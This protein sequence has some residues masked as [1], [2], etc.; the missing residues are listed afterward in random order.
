MRLRLVTAFFA[1]FACGLAFLAIFLWQSGRLRTIAAAPHSP[2]SPITQPATPP[3]R[4]PDTASP[5]LPPKSPEPA[6]IA[7][8]PPAVEAPDAAREKL[9]DRIPDQALTSRKLLMPVQGVRAKELRDN[10]NE[11]RGNH[12]H[13]A[14]D[15]MAPRG[16][17]VLAADEGNVVKLFLS[18]PGGLT[19]YQFDDSRTYCYYYAHLDRYAPALKEGMLLRKGDVLGYVGSSG[20]ASPGAP[21]LHFAIFKLGP[22]QHWWQGT[23]I[24]P[25]RTL[26]SGGE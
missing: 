5:Y 25:Y 23:P 9:P 7:A 2:P 22:E 4:K 13:E 17:P 21:H 14:I 15:I 12:R 11:I 26:T 19:V 3:A 6:P 24:N 18:K 1:G 10:F 8:S 20:D 16:T